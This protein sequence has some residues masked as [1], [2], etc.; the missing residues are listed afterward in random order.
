MP[1]LVMAKIIIGS[2][3]SELVEYRGISG[4]INAKIG[5]G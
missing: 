4:P 5:G 2:I 3:E 1:V